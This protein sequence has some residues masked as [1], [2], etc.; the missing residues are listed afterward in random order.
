MVRTQPSTASSD[1]KAVYDPDREK[2]DNYYG[3][4]G[5]ADG[6]AKVDDGDLTFN[7]EPGERE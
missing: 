2:T 1:V 7:R 5:T 6:P 3:G 4:Q